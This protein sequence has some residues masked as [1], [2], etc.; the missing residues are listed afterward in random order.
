M[1]KVCTYFC[2]KVKWTDAIRWYDNKYVTLTKEKW[3][4]KKKK[5][6]KVKQKFAWT[7]YTE[8]SKPIAVLHAY[9]EWSP[10][11]R[12]QVSRKFSDVIINP[13]AMGDGSKIAS[14]NFSLAQLLWSGFKYVGYSYTIVLLQI[15]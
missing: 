5:K 3:N 15:M 13:I 6:N 12:S 2:T 7:K 11:H 10:E 8:K 9:M 4:E 1:G 14:R